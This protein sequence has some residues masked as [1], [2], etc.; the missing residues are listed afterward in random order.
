MNKSKFSKYSKAELEAYD[1]KLMKYKSCKRCEGLS[2]NVSN[3]LCPNCQELIA[4]QN[5][6]LSYGFGDLRD[7]RLLY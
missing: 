2:Q 7:P 4:N 5:K 1:R 6:P 3:G